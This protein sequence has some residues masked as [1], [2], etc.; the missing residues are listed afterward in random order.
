MLLLPTHKRR[1]TTGVR[2][3]LH[4][5]RETYREYSGAGAPPAESN[6]HTR[7]PAPSPGPGALLAERGR[8]VARQVGGRTRDALTRHEEPDVYLDVPTLK[9]DEIDLELDELSAR[10]SLEAHVL[11]LLRLDVGADV[12]LGRVNLQIKG[13]EAQAQLKVRLDNLGV[14]LDRV[15]TT[16][17]R[18]PEVLERLADQVGRA[19][20]SAVEG[21][22]GIARELPGAGLAGKR[23]GA[24]AA[25]ASR[26]NG[27]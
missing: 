25:Q 16:V 22:G 18:N 7:P 1:R 11:D 19:A 24:R 2:A 10:V 26:G 5:A 20:G 17:E 15:M 14:I 3:A 6:G 4:R 23:P 13:V 21:V 12:H 8:R 27:T 9:V